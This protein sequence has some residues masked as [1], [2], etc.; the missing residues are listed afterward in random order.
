MHS[1]KSISVEE[2]SRKRLK[3]FIS[4]QNQS[5]QRTDGAEFVQPFFS[6]L[7]NIGWTKQ[8]EKNMFQQ[9]VFLFM[10]IVYFMILVLRQMVGQTRNI[11]SYQIVI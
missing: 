11:Y 1:N 10:V 3:N 2:S 4:T 8:L 6:D 7:P 5:L 9:M